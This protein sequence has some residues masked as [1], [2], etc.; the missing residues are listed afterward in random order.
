M[1]K[2]T[3]IVVTP[4]TDAF[5]EGRQVTRQLIEPGKPVTMDEDKAK[6][7]LACGALRVPDVIEGEEGDSGK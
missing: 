3:Y 2:K 1:V 4:L 5:Q 7:L 6:P